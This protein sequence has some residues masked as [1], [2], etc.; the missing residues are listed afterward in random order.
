MFAAAAA[1]VDAEFALKRRKPALQGA[2]HAGGDAGGMPVHSHHGAERLK[3]ERMRQPLQELVAS[4]VMDDGLA[5]D[6]AERAQARAQ[7]WRNAPAVKGKIRAAAPSCHARSI[8][9]VC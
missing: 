2:D 1:D 3:P 4:V 5:D 7:P 6:G 8:R 9:L